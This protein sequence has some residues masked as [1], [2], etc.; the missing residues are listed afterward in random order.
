MAG[1]WVMRLRDVPTD[2]DAVFGGGELTVM[3]E[4][5]GIGGRNT[6]FAL[7]AAIELERLRIDHWTVASLAT[8]GED[9]MT[10]VAGAMVDCTTPAEL[11]ARHI[12]PITAL[13]ANDSFPGSEQI[14]AAVEP[15]P[16]APM[17]TTSISRSGNGP[18]ESI[19]SRQS[20]NPHHLARKRQRGRSDSAY[21]RRR[22][23]RG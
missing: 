18:S 22:Y 20:G 9:G 15:G 5:D 2:I 7:A 10:D 23:W 8:D 14:G 4:G 3:V 13:H 1:E 19:Y 17:S 16:P 6:E 21:P 12:D 11:R